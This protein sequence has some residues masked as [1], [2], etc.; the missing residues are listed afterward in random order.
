[1]LPVLFSLGGVSISSYG[2]SL[3]LAFISAIYIC[4]KLARLYEISEERILD[5]GI[6]TFFGSL[7]G[8]RAYFILTH[9]AVFDNFN[10]VLLISR[11]PGLSLWG[12]FIGGV[13]ALWF[14]STRAKLNF[15]Q[16]AD[17]AAVSLLLALFF[18]DIGC[19][20]G[21]CAYGIPS[22]LPIATS[23]VGVIGKRLPTTLLEAVLLL[24]VFSYIW[25]QAIRYHFHGKIVAVSF[26]FLG[27]IKFITEF[28]RGDSLYITGTS[29]SQG[30]LW[31]L[32]LAI[33]GITV[34]Y[35]R[36]K[37]SFFADCSYLVNLPSSPKKR[38]QLL[39]RIRKNWYNFAVDLRIKSASFFQRGKSLPKTLKRRLNVKSTPKNF[40]QS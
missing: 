40:N 11:Y 36:S 2:V 23:V 14:F 8:A 30:Y 25:K 4:W 18:G 26:I 33:C 22:N 6:L 3:G 12:G 17:F 35:K 16:L 13:L 20:F 29:I 10:K 31:S 37:R 32:A 28:F 9:L 38:K 19:F 34:Y 24:I 5:L 1:M 15:W 21:G 7:I 39:L 27:I